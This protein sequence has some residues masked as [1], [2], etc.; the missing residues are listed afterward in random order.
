MVEITDCTDENSQQSSSSSRSQPSVSLLVYLKSRGIDSILWILRIIT[1]VFGVLFV[2]SSGKEKPSYYEKTLLSAAATNALRLQQRIGR[3]QFN[4]GFIRRLF[5][6]DASHYLLF[7]LTLLT[8]Y[9]IT[10]GIAPVFLFA[11]LHWTN[12]TLQLL[13]SIGFSHLKVSHFLENFLQKYMQTL[14]HISAY[15]E[16][17]LLPV[18]IF[19]VLNGKC[20]LIIPFIHYRFLVMRYFSY[21]NP[22][23]RVAFQEFRIFFEKIAYHRSC[24]SLFRRVIL[25]IIQYAYNYD[26]EM[27]V[28][29]ASDPKKDSDKTEKML[30]ESEKADPYQALQQIRV[31]AHNRR[32][33]FKV[34]VLGDPGVGKT[35]L[36]FRFCNGRFPSNSTPTIG[37]DF[38]EK[39]IDLDGETLR[40][41]FWDTAGQ[42]RFQQSMIAHYYR[43]VNAVIF[44][45][46]VSQISSFRNLI[47]WIEECQKHNIFGTV[48]MILIG[49]KCD[50]ESVVTTEEAQIFADKHD[51]PLFLTSAQD[52]LEL[53]HVES[54]FMTLAHILQKNKSLH[55]TTDEERKNI[56]ILIANCKVRTLIIHSLTPDY[57][58]SFWPAVCGF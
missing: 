9:P 48:P 35:C 44:V 38:R 56:R 53:N 34:I 36:T 24:P 26:N 29:E 30:K 6:E 21:R 41:Q 10:F 18:L 40:V 52:D 43:N 42:E 47:R 12:F 7:S 49:N 39:I 58:K 45:Y 17:L 28:L 32:R 46:D 55:V 8:V 57:T 20:Q 19:L 22:H 16:I 23:T 27:S 50:L 14:L 3:V 15:C 1:I 54:I 13:K 2:I 11:L 37:V 5:A 31:V 25:K 51:M 4:M 33:T